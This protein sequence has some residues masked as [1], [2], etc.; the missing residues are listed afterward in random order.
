MQILYAG[1]TDVGKVR[2]HNE[3]AYA[4]LPDQNLIMVCDGMGGHA[5]GEVAS[6]M[7]VETIST[8]CGEHDLELFTG[9]SL[10]YPEELTPEGKLLVGAIAVAN[11][12]IIDLAQKSSSH[13]GMGTTVV[14][15]HYKDGIVSIC[16]VGDSRAYLIRNGSI[17]R[18]TIDHSWVS[19]VMEKH[20]LSEEES[21]NL[22]NRNV[23]TRALGTRTAIRTDIS[24]IRIAKDDVFLLCSD[25]LCG[26]VS[27]TDILHTVMSSVDDLTR[28]VSELTAKANEAGG[29]D[30]ITVA[31]AKVIEQ[32]E[33]PDFDEVRRVTVDWSEDKCTANI[34]E[35]VAAKFA[36]DTD[37]PA[38]PA[39][40]T[41]NFVV[42]VTKEHG[43]SPVLWIAIV[44]VVIA[45][46]AF[47]FIK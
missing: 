40:D 17:K 18:V 46:I 36:S 23:I 30:N 3:D 44:V 34:A 11:R 13:T 10:P 21:E 35:I 38:A 39:G 9:E 2:D 31:L 20:H 4:V 12:R 32:D 1:G 29:S 27:D 7:A 14:A 6:Q 41:V 45:A 5:A 26:M 33:I 28:I 24:Q 25:G 19:E 8:I 42:P 43:I 47:M 37:I 15:C 22:V 16:H